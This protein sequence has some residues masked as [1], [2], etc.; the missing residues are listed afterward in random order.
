MVNKS[1]LQAPLAPGLVTPPSSDRR[2]TRRSPLSR[3]RR[4]RTGRHGRR[5]HR[6]ARGQQRRRLERPAEQPGCSHLRQRF[7]VARDSEVTENRNGVFLYGA[8]NVNIL[9]QHHRQQPHRHSPRQRRDWAVGSATTSSR[10]TGRWV[11]CSV[12]S[13]RR[14]A[15]VRSRCRT[16]TSA[17]TGTARSRLGRCSAPPPRHDRELAGNHCAD[18]RWRGALR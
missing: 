6:D 13:A 1:N 5:L 16:T 12:T 10:T 3:S 8:Q 2:A 7:D 14:T 18:R 15:P 4:Q 17:A 9:Q 11:S